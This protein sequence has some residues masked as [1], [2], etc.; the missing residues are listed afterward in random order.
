[1]GE[2]E[3]MTILERLS[4]LYKEME[5][6]YDKVAT[7]LDFSC[8]GCPDNCCDSYFQH[9]THVEWAYL[10]EGFSQLPQERQQ[11]YLRRSREY[12]AAAQAAL[13]KGERPVVLCPLN[14]DGLCGLYSHRLM[15]C[16]LHGVPTSMTLPDGQKKSFPGCAVCQKLTEGQ[17]NTPAM[18]R[19]KF[20]REMVALERQYLSTARRPL[21]KVKMTIAEMLL[22]GDPG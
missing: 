7:L 22:K 11:T 4:G 9:H 12:V 3:I 15:I 17:S 8:E 14:D 1:M 5:E 10:W 2:N 20:F 16:R 18:D 21:S 19:T 6:A 13:V